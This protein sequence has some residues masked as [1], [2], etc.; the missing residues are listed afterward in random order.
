M[1]PFALS[2]LL[3]LVYKGTKRSTVLEKERKAIM[4]KQKEIEVGDQRM[5][6]WFSMFYS[7]VLSVLLVGFEG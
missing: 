2:V 1:L 4:D 7:F 6:L 5:F 3:W